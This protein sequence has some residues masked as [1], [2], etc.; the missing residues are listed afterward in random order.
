MTAP[1]ARNLRIGRHS[2]VGRIYLVTTVISGRKPLFADFAKARVLIR[3]LRES[4]EHA[5]AETLAFVVMPDHLHWLL[6][7]G[8][9]RALSDV[10]GTLKSLSARRL[11]G[12]VWQAGFHDHAVRQEE[13]LLALARYVVANPLRAG[14][15]SRIGDYPHWDAAWL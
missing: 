4:E 11:G 6:S 8:E 7:L 14:L 3:L 15:V 1:H 13:D 9:K 12:P 10:I 5:L 2:E